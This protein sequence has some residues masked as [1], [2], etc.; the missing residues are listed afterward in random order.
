M[1]TYK[2]IIIGNGLAESKE[3][4]TPS[5]R[6]QLKTLVNLETKQYVERTFYADLWLS[7]NAKDRT[8]DTLRAIGYEGNS[9]A[10]LNTPCLVGYEVEVST[11]MD[12]YNGNM[13]EKVNFVNAVG[14]FAKRGVKPLDENVTRNLASRYDS[15]FRN[16]KPTAKPV[17]NM[18]AVKNAQVQQNAKNAPQNAYSA[19][20]APNAPTF[21]SQE[22]DLPF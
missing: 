19:H 6:L 7:D 2:A 16:K 22:D 21:N 18:E 12:E 20:G 11:L 10:E 8:V 14:S 9:I 5:V 1:A 3:K 13:T 17:I 15:L 4:H